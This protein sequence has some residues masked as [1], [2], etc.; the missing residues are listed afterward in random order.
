MKCFFPILFLILSSLCFAENIREI[1]I[2]V[3]VL[4]NKKPSTV[5]FLKGDFSDTLSFDLSHSTDFSNVESLFLVAGR[6]SR[7]STKL[8]VIAKATDIQETVSLQLTEKVKAV[9]VFVKM[10]STTDLLSKLSVKLV[11]SKKNYKHRFAVSLVDETLVKGA[12]IPG[13]VTTPKGTL[14]AVYDA[15]Y[16]QVKDLQ[17]HMD[18]ALNRSTDGGQTWSPMQKII[19]MGEWGGLPEKYNGVSDAC[20]VVDD[21][22][23]K[24][25]V[26]GLWMHGVKDKT[27]K[28]IGA[29]GWNH[30]W[31]QGGSMPGLEPKETSQFMMVE[32]TDDG[33]T[34]STPKN[35][36]KE[37][38][39]PEWVLFAP[40]PGRGITMKNGTLVM[41]TQGRL[42]DGIP[43]SNF[44][45]SQDKGKT[46]QVSEPAHT[47]TTECQIVELKDGSL[48]LNMRDNRNNT[49]KDLA[50]A[51]RS[52]YVTS[53]L[54]KTWKMHPTSRKALPEPVC[55]AG[56]LA[57]GPQ[58]LLVFSNPP[59][60][61]SGLGRRRMTMKFSL[62]QGMTWPEKHH[63]LLD[64]VKGAYSC[65]TSVSEDVIGILY[66]G[67]QAR[68][69]FM[70]V[71]LQDV[72][73]E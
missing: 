58:N 50:S 23:G 68:M 60:L 25:F 26:T 70:K 49:A 20:I 31:R 13:I 40:A 54:G 42:A 57:H 71:P 29:K 63:L 11:G 44:I 32:S 61:R 41:P 12:R 21:Q 2:K 43:F 47:D 45:Y 38:K 36:T 62:D 37:L 4:I 55:C 34:W 51:G 5:L 30:Q 18:I 22:T 69:T 3:P 27:G 17:G 72:G 1:P 10:K 14:L 6:Q 56:F 15:R 35:L 65:L 7:F 8:K 16:D 33:V 66:E 52:V 73:L 64:D 48:M 59:T 9:T 28:W 24:V 67:S 46:W 53:D 19:D 39:K